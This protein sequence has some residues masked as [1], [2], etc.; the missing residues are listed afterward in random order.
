M[1]EFLIEHS[2]TLL[3]VLAAFALGAW[4]ENRGTKV[5]SD[6]EGDVVDLKNKVEGLI[7]KTST[8]P[9]VP[10]APAS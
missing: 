9:G 1:A 8:P 2:V 4:V 3:A 6:I 10:S 5:I 7:T